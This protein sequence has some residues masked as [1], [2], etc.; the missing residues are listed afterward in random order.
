[1][2]LP[3]AWI[4]GTAVH[5]PQVTPMRELL[6]QNLITADDATLSQIQSVAISRSSL[7]GVDLAV[8]A[9]MAAVKRGAQDPASITAHIHAF[10]H[11]LDQPTLLNPSVEIASALGLSQRTL[12]GNQLSMCDGMNALAW[13]LPRLDTGSRAC[14][15]LTTGSTW[16]RR[17]DR[18][19]MMPAL[20]LGDAGAALAVT[21]GR[22]RSRARIVSA[23]TYFEPRLLGMHRPV[24]SE[25]VYPID[26]RER[27]DAYAT[28]EGVSAQMR[29]ELIG[30][31]VTAAVRDA[32]HDAAI[33]VADVTHVIGSF[34]SPHLFQLEFAGP[35]STIGFKPRQFAYGVE[36]GL[37]IG[38][39]GPSDTLIGLDRLLPQSSPNDVILL[40]GSAAGYTWTAA[41]I[42]VY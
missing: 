18:F 34:L 37:G 41:V 5:L 23:G 32:L 19:H 2:H 6:A 11:S 13:L 39:T 35:L 15:L 12:V 26:F 33:D 17:V 3:T 40:I 38:H 14:I 42:R 29:Y 7:R 10:P 8:E 28:R 1:M 25:E 27:S 16:S 22:N 4:S 24:T 30:N 21:S 20:V 36:L 31:G 9:G